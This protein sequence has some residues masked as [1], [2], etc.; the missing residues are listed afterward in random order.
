VPYALYVF[1]VGFSWGPSVRYLHEHH[2][3]G[4]ILHTHGGELALALCVFA[5]LLVLG[6]IEELR[7]R[8]W[9]VLLYG[10]VPFAAV[11][12][13]SWQNAKAFNPRYVILALPPY[14]VLVVSGLA[15]MPIRT[16][17][18]WALLVVGL[19]SLSMAKYYGDPRYQRENVRD[20]VRWVEHRM[21]PEECLFAPTVTEVVE[22]YLEKPRRVRSVFTP[23]GTP[24]EVV[25]ARLQRAL[26]GCD[27]LWYLR[28]RP[29]ENDADER[30]LRFLDSRYRERERREFPGV[31]IIHFVPKGED[32]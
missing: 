2:R 7:R 28:A 22:F 17:P 6:V 26:A 30:I 23:R 11:L 9:T 16:R 32:R 24:P 15:R 8:R 29:W 21:A 27:R 14:L 18:I 3:V 12:A 5:P 20:A 13:L 4:E 1:G 31:Q 10:I 19:S 25:R